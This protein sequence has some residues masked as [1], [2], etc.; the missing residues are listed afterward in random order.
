[1]NASPHFPQPQRNGQPAGLPEGS[2]WSFRAQGETTTGKPRRMAQHPG[3]GQTQPEG[4]SAWADQVG[5]A[6]TTLAPPAG[7]RTSA[8]LLPGSRRPPA[9]RRPPATVWQPFGL[10]NAACPNSTA[11]WDSAPYP[12]D[13]TPPSV[14]FGIGPFV[15]NG[16]I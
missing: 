14:P 12:Q 4:V 13:A 1:M 5:L 15:H 6:V 3:G 9:P 10:T 7:V 2:R 16:T 11:R 8:A